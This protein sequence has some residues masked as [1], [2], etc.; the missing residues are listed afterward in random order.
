M[1]TWE[2]T[3]LPDR[4]TAHVHRLEGELDATAL[5]R[6]RE[7]LE[8][9]RDEVLVLDLSQVGHVGAAALRLLAVDAE[10]RRRVGGALRLVGVRY[11]LLRVLAGAG[12]LALAGALPASAVDAPGPEALPLPA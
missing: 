11:G 6:L 12:L 1:S 5:S 2:S 7:L 9:P 4:G 8:G 10:L 3:A